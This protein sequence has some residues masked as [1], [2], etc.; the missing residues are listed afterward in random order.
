V[1]EKLV[2]TAGSKITA[3]VITVLFSS[4]AQPEAVAVLIRYTLNLLFLNAQVIHN[5]DHH[6]LQILA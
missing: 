1:V 2:S 6:S 3:D 5:S 4:S